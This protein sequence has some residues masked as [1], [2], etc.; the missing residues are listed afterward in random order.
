MLTSKAGLGAI[1]NLWI[2][3]P[4]AG[5]NDVVSLTGEDFVLMLRSNRWFIV[6]CLVSN[7][8]RMGTTLIYRTTS[9]PDRALLLTVLRAKMYLHI[10]GFPTLHI[11][12]L[13]SKFVPGIRL[14][15]ASVITLLMVSRYL[16]EQFNRPSSLIALGWQK[17]K[18]VPK[19][20]LLPAWRRIRYRP[21]EVLDRIETTLLHEVF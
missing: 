14:S 7:Y 11:C 2:Q 16:D 1:M 4:Q 9:G 12:T 19:A 18:L 3:Q 15:Q 21:I 17:L 20:M 8:G 6:I 13:K 10:P 5:P